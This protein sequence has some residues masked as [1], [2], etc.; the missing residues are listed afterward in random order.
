MLKKGQAALEFLSTY[1]W[2]F[3]V[4]LLMISAIT[5]FI[6][7]NPGFIPNQCSFEADLNCDD[8][9]ITVNAADSASRAF[10]VLQQ[11][12]GRPI[13]LVDFTCKDVDLQV[14]GTGNFV[15]SDDTAIDMSAISDDEKKWD[16]REDVVLMC[17]LPGNPYAGLIGEGVQLKLDITYLTRE[18]GFEHTFSG[19]LYSKI[20]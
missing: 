5:S 20:I 7:F 14:E 13:Y 18:N 3:I 2:A 1:G 16:S 17:E 4:V 11:T 6:V 12:T 19:E 9:M 10:I 8:Y 15:R